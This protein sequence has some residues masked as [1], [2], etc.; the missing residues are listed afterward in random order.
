MAQRFIS[1]ISV[2]QTVVQNLL[3]DCEV[4]LSGLQP[5]FKNREQKLKRKYQSGSQ[6]VRLS[7]ILILLYNY[8]CI[9]IFTFV[10]VLGSHFNDV[11]LW[12]VAKH[13]IHSLL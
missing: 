7:K 1:L 9:Y 11:F 6:R 10:C 2:F 13:D 5:L 4:K 3:I 8:I 12:I